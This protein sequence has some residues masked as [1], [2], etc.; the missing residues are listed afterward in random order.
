MIY[1]AGNITKENLDNINKVAIKL[2]VILIASI[3][4]LKGR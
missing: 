2:R 4:T 3:K 1:N